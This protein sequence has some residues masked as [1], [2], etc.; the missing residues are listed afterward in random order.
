MKDLVSEEIVSPC[1]GGEVEYENFS[2]KKVD[3]DEIPTIKRTKLMFRALALR[4]R[5]FINHLERK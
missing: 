2:V 5:K 1:V 4:Q 3:K